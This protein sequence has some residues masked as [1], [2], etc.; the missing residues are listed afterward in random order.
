[1]D[2]NLSTGSF[3]PID[4]AYKNTTQDLVMRRA[5]ESGC[6]VKLNKEK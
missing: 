6:S 1:M 5:G 4:I 3:L 2:V